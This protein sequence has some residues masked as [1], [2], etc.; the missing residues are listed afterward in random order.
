MW[1]QQQQQ[2]FSIG[3]YD[4]AVDGDAGRITVTDSRSAQ[5]GQPLWATPSS[6]PFVQAA[7]SHDRIIGSSGCWKILRHD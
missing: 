3:V 5:G 7:R 2:A 6:G 4:I 1:R